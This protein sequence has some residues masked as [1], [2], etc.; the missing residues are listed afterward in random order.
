MKLT[1]EKM[2]MPM[3][4][5]VFVEVSPENP[6]KELKSGVLITSTDIIYEDG[7]GMEG[8]KV[9][10]DRMIRFGTVVELGDEC[11][12]LEY[13]DEVYFDSRGMMPIPIGIPGRTIVRLNER[14]I[15]AYVRD[16]AE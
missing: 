4:D 12:Y 16:N 2:I 11:K 8:N 13:D 6:Y 3:Q 9:E 5:Y 7:D 15:L 10:L 14:N 1:D